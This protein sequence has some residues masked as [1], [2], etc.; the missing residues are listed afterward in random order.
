MQQNQYRRVFG[1]GF[2]VKDGDP[3]YLY[4]AIKSGMFH[5]TFLS[6]NPDGQIETNSKIPFRVS[7]PVF[8]K[9]ASV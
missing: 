5:G 1:P 9:H 4:R 8:R 2:S 6:H 7:S 3:V